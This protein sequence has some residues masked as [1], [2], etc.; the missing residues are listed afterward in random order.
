MRRFVAELAAVCVA[1]VLAG[2]GGGGGSSTPPP[3]PVSISISPSSV[4]VP[5]GSSQQFVATVLNSNNTGATWKVNGT[6]GGNSTVGTINTNGLYQAPNV[7]PNPATVTV[8]AVAKADTSKSAS[9]STTVTV[10]I[11]VSPTSAEL[12]LAQNQ[13]FVGT[14][15]GSNNTGLTWSLTCD[16]PVGAPT[17]DPSTI[18]TLTDN[19]DGTALYTA[20]N[21]I[22]DNV[23]TDSSGELSQLQP[24]AS[25]ISVVAAWQQDNSQIATAAVFV[26]AGSQSVNQA[27]Q[28]APVKLGTS[29]G[30]ANDTTGNFCCSGTLGAL[31]KRV[32]TNFVLSNNHVLAK[33]DT[34]NIGDDISQPGLVDTNCNPGA[35]VAD[36]SQFIKLRNP[37]NCTNNCTAVADAAIGQ[38]VS[39]KVDTTGSILQFGTVTGGLADAAPPANTTGSATV[40]MSV[41][42]S[43]RTSGLSCSTIAA[44][45]ASIQVG[46][47]T[48][49]NG[50][51]NFTVSYTNQLV[52]SST[53]FGAP[54]DSGSLIVDATTAQPV[55]LLYAGSDTDTV[56]N[57]IGTVL[58]NLKDGGGHAPAIVGG[59]QHEV[60]ACTGNIGPMPPHGIASAR[61]L[62]DADYQRAL[63]AKESHVKELLS[64]PAVIGVGVGM[65]ESSGE[66]AVVVFVEKGKKA[67]NIPAEVDGIKT[68]IHETKPFRAFLPTQCPKPET[69]PT[70]AERLSGGLHQIGLPDWTAAGDG[71]SRLQ[72]RQHAPCVKD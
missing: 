64:I 43:G 45:N 53:S 47:E 33:R 11:S 42:K 24:A 26:N 37:A 71:E 31:V 4:N 69:V 22:P 39:G 44:T 13:L 27:V 32:T 40:G 14:V 72:S 18:G 52:I 60:E 30:N 68:R 41:A 2:C 54:G 12:L 55:G 8:T 17:C 20:P 48:G 34:G 16:T 28:S 36:L 66:P 29:G 50:G 6:V 58:S 67:G 9:A 38:I 65:G 5:A 23:L 15:T 1:L 61:V 63:A 59:A 7:V 49:C 10:G 57:P 25:T 21:A 56:G 35:R 46:Y 70:F 3:P 19:G 51:T 62:G